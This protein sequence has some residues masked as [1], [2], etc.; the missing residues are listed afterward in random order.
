M[1]SWVKWAFYGKKSLLSG[2]I[3]MKNCKISHVAYWGSTPKVTLY[4]QKYVCE[5]EDRRALCKNR[6]HKHKHKKLWK[7]QTSSCSS[8]QIS[9]TMK[10]ATLM[11]FLCIAMKKP[12]LEVGKLEGMLVKSCWWLS[13]DPIASKILKPWET[14]AIQISFST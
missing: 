3:L 2:T 6:K 14:I 13:G 4:R 12:L 1:K 9:S 7:L 5:F 10:K 8:A 11:I